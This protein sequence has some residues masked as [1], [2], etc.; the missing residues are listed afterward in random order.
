M[1][2]RTSVVRQPGSANPIVYKISHGPQLVY[3]DETDTYV[4]CPPDTP[5]TW[6]Y[7]ERSS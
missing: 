4:M 3:D 2:I 5:V 6:L 7:V 1:P